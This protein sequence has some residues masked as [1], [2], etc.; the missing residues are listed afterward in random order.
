MY[1][2]SPATPEYPNPIPYSVEELL[3]HSGKMVLLDT[4]LE[5]GEN[6]V[7]AELT[8]REDGLFSS[9]HSVPAWVG[10]EYMAQAVAAL[11]GYHRKRQGLDIQLG[12]LLGTRF[13]ESSVDSFPCGS[14]LRVRAEKV[15]DGANDMSVFD[16]HIEGEHIQA[17]SKLNL[18]LPKDA[19]A[20]LAV[21][22]I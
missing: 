1:P 8:V 9:E 3:P 12:F 6:H 16:C 15:M 21:K 13:Y 2:W 19:E 20:Y 22:G 14:L 11:S 10:I 17:A 18:L 5:A 4:V 7:V